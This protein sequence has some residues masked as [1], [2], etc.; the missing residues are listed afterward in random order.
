MIF[1]RGPC[2][3]SVR[4]PPMCTRA[5]GIRNCMRTGALRRGRAPRS[6]DK[7]SNGFRAHPCGKLYRRSPGLP[8]CRARSRAEKGQGSRLRRSK[9]ASSRAL[10]KPPLGKLNQTGW[11]GLGK[12][13]KRPCR[14]RLYIRALV[15]VSVCALRPVPEK[16][17]FSRGPGNFHQFHQFHQSG[18]CRV[19]VVL[20]VR[21]WAV[22]SLL[23]T[24]PACRLSE[25]PVSETAV[26]IVSLVKRLDGT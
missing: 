26:A 20:W 19:S 7:L 11:T 21:F 2:T 13:R 23:L 22:G 15:C 9:S 18:I 6:Q 1:G 12:C 16:K 25:W 14:L 10:Q 5:F 4:R 8:Y 17:I 3:G 24:S